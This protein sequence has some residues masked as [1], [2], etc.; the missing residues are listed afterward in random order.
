MPAINSE[1]F[2]NEVFSD[3]FKVNKKEIIK[4]KIKKKAK[5]LMPSLSAPVR[6]SI[7]LTRKI[8]PNITMK[9]VYKVSISLS[10]T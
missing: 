2:S 5:N 3:V 7:K 8:I 6:Y 10:R 9:A 1:S 4:R